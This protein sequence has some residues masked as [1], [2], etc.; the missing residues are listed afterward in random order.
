MVICLFADCR[1]FYLLLPIGNEFDNE[2]GSVG[3]RKWEKQPSFLIIRKKK[4]KS[5]RIYTQTMER[6][7]VHVYTLYMY[8]MIYAMNAEPLRLSS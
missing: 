4:R 3:G 1:L 8:Q 5:R 7:C 2:N 6:P